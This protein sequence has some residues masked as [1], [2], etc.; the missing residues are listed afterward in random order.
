MG[1][2]MIIVAR[3][4]HRARRENARRENRPDDEADARKAVIAAYARMEGVLARHGVPR[5]ASETPLEYLSR[6]L[7]DLTARHEPVARLTD[8]FEVAKFSRRAVGPD[9][10]RDAIDALQEIRDELAAAT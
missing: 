9:M 8:L 3:A 10:K 4:R 2:D 5:L 7:S 1:R 6:V